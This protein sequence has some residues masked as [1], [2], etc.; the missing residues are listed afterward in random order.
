[1]CLYI[2]CR[3]VTNIP[4]GVCYNYTHTPL[5]LSSMQAPQ[6]NSVAASVTNTPNDSSSVCIENITV[7]FDPTTNT[8]IVE[9]QHRV[10]QLLT[11]DLPELS[12]ALKYG[13][14]LDRATL[15]VLFPECVR[16]EGRTASGRERPI[17]LI[18][19]NSRGKLIIVKV[20]P[21]C[22]PLQHFTKHIMQKHI[23]RGAERHKFQLHSTF[24]LGVKSPQRM[25]S[26]SAKT[27]YYSPWFLAKI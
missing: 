19:E 7:N 13:M 16:W 9:L 17:Y 1:M 11:F 20:S 2:Q 8:P 15:V 27:P 10:E 21:K 12:S 4:L 18:F 6:I 25:T 22:C 26:I 14:W 23:S 3:T 24:H 5:P